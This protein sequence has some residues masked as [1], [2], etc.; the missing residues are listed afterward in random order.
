[1]P[2][3][4]R[5]ELAALYLPGSSEASVGGDWYDALALDDGSD[6]RS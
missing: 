6:R 1:M 2:Q 3:L 4:D 5:A